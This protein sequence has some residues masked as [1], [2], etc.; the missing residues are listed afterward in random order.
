MTAVRWPEM[1]PEQILP[2]SLDPALGSQPILH[3]VREVR[4]QQG[5]SVR[6]AAR[7]LGMEARQVRELENPHSDLRL[8][9]LYRWQEVLEV[10]LSELLIEPLE[11]LS[12][13]IMERARLVK[14]MKTAQAM[15]EKAPTPAMK[16]M[17]QMFIEQLCEMMPELAGVG[18]W[19]AVGKRR[20]SDEVGKIGQHEVHLEGGHRLED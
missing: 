16:R 2:L 4:V 6:T 17:A 9:E 18:P 11:S 5:I 20:S 14:L 1:T 8:T 12:R 15:L 10:P 13:P 3:R 7:H 19:P